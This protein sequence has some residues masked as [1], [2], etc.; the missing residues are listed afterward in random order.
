MGMSE[1]TSPPPVDFEKI[2]QPR[3]IAVIGVSRERVKGATGFL[4]ALVRL[5]YP[6]RIYPVNPELDEVL[7]LRVYPS[8]SSIPDEV[9]YAI[10]GVP[11]HLVPAVIDECARKGIAVAQIFSSGFAEVG[12]KE[13][14]ALQEAIVAAARGRIR[15]IGPNCMGV[16]NPAAR[17]GFEPE[18]PLE[19]GRVGFISQSGGLAMSFI[20][21]ASYERIGISKL[22]S[23]GNACDLKVTD[24]LRYFS[25]DPETTVVGMYL[26]GLREGEYG[27]FFDLAR[28]MTPRKPLVLWKS[29]YTE[30][31]ARAT[32]SHTASMAG[33]YTIW[34][35][36]AKQAGVIV[37]HTMDELI[38]VTSLLVRLPLPAGDNIGILGFGGGT[39]VTTTDVCTSLGLSVPA[40]SDEVQQKILAFIPEAGTFRVNPVDL[41]AWIVNPRI[42]RDVG[43][44]V[45]NTPNIDV[46]LYVLDVEF[47]SR[48]CERLSLEPD[49]MVNGHAK[50][51]VRVREAT[52]KPVISVL[53]KVFEGELAA[54]MR[55]QFQETGMPIFPTVERAARAL[56]R[57][58][59]YRSYLRSL[60]AGNMG[61]RSTP[62]AAPLSERRIFFAL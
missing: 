58:G 16:Y 12:T 47:I 30:A 15:I 49:R 25:E 24:F 54:K 22:V 52:G 39:C 20:D 11:A 5:G 21:Y 44:T 29:G 3:S 7:G 36:V 35:A 27:E 60:T 31:G 32:R 62:A 41:T 56:A 40:L 8:V 2:F 55:A 46:L 4:H 18:Q 33:S 51:L 53:Q 13:G 57:A 26:E 45:G 37:V 48:T 28:A 61:A 9:D 6:G 19:P 42:S 50:S 1:M 34:R 10:I 38:D 59:E 43:L 17:L 23:L 14:D